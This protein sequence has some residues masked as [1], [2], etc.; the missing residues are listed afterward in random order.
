MKEA[1]HVLRITHR[2]L[3]HHKYKVMELL[4]IKTSAELVQYAI[5]HGIISV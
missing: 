2:T 3:A 1:A 5:K 4:Q